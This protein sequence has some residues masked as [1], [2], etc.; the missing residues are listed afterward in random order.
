M[1]DGADGQGF[2]RF[3][4]LLLGPGACRTREALERRSPVPRLHALHC[5]A[6]RRA[7]LRRAVSFHIFL[8]ALVTLHHPSHPPYLPHLPLAAVA[9]HQSPMPGSR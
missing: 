9:I 2:V 4:S 8:Y 1:A 7:A 6:L 5:T 3:D